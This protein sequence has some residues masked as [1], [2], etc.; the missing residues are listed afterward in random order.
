MKEGESV[1]DYVNDSE[2]CLDSEDILTSACSKVEKACKKKRFSGLLS[3]RLMEIL[4]MNTEVMNF[5][6]FLN[7]KLKFK[8]IW[9]LLKTAESC[10]FYDILTDWSLSSQNLHLWGARCSPCQA[11]DK[12]QADKSGVVRNKHYSGSRNR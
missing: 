12:Y 4:N 1:F 7:S 11:A 6:E 5:S 9:L 2:N 10:C 8:E 3:S